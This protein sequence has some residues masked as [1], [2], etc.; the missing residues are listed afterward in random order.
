[1]DGLVHLAACLGESVCFFVAGDAYMGRYPLKH[2]LVV[3]AEGAQAVVELPGG[4]VSG[5]RREGL[6]GRQGVREKDDILLLAVF[7]C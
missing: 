5:A 4:E 2:D 7:P 1:M 3:V 6:E